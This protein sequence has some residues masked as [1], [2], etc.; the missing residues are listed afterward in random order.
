MSALRV[1]PK[2]LKF[3]EKEKYQPRRFNKLK[4]GPRVTF[5]LTEIPYII[6][7]GRHSGFPDCC[8]KFFVTKW[9]WAIDNPKSKLVKN[10]WDNNSKISPGYIACP[11]CLKN[12][13]FVRKINSCPKT[14]PLLKFIW[15]KNWWTDPDD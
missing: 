9:I 6:Q 11:K 2:R 8:I 15:G 14:C 13:T 7:C 4:K 3:D 12:K 10:Y 5:L 1:H